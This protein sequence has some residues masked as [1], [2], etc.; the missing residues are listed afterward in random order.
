STCAGLELLHYLTQ[1]GS[2]VLRVVLDDFDG[3]TAYAQYDSFH[4]DAESD[5][6]AL[7]VSGFYDGGAG[8]SLTY[9]H[10]QNFSTFDNDQ[11]NSMSNCAQRFHGAFWYNACYHTNPTGLYQWEHETNHYSNGVIWSK[12]KGYGY[13]VKRI[14]MMFRPS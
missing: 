10:G 7:H 11:D 12:W 9:H 2:Y 13:S 8:D 14:T 3:D 6:Y 4:I 1:N 5:G